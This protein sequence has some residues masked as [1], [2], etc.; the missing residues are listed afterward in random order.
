MALTS[1]NFFQT[2]SFL[3][4]INTVAMFLLISCIYAVFAVDLFQ[5]YNPELFGNFGPSLY[6]LVQVGAVVTRLS[7][8]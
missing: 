5:D 8:P 2:T 4:I 7:H 6:S 3:A 1:E